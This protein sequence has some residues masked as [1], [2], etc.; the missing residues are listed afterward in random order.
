MFV[1]FKSSIVSSASPHTSQIIHHVSII[2]D[3]T[4]EMLY[5]GRQLKYSFFL[6]NRSTSADFMEK[7]LIYENC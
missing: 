3:K 4:G 2:K 1:M 6:Q 7:K 5:V